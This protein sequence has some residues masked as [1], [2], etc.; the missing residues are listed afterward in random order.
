MSDQIPRRLRARIERALAAYR[1]V[2]VGGPRQVGKTTLAKELLGAQGTFRQLDRDDTLAAAIVDPEGFAT[3]GTPPRV[4]DEVQLAGDNL[5]RAIKL[6]VDRDNMPGQYLLTGSADFLSVPGLS[7]SLAGRAVFFDLWPFSQGELRGRPDAFLD[8]LFEDPASLKSGPRSDVQR[9]DYLDAICRGGFPEAVRMHSDDR[10]P[11]FDSLVRTVTQRDIADLTGAKRAGELPRLLR[12]LAARTANELVMTQ[13]HA[14]T[15][16]ARDTVDAYTGFLRITHLVHELPAWSR[17]LTNRARKR[18][19][20]YLT[21]TGLASHLLGADTRGLLRPEDKRRGPLGETF[22]VNEL[23]KQLGWSRTRAELHHFRDRDGSE[24]DIVAETPDGR[25]A[26]IE[27]KTALTV[28]GKDFAQLGKLRD[29]LGDDFMHGVV[30]SFTDTPLPFG[31]RLTSL[32]M[33]YLW[34]TD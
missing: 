14:D 3:L 32:P 31:D 29:A 12:L 16:L 18:P 6:Q 34:E 9:E 27:V 22:V 11:W 25:V 13:L 17:N 4:I 10:G 8:R 2:V 5:I 20:S 19:K 23:R 30:L 1:V 7:E 26:A 15:G 33:S 24:V 21:D 28:T